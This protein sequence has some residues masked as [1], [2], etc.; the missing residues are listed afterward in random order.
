MNSADAAEQNIS[1]GQMVRIFGENGEIRIK[2]SLTEDI[3][4]GVASLDAGRWPE[5]DGGIEVA[6]SANIVTSTEPTRPSGGS[7][8]HSTFVDIKPT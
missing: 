1:D 3:M 7:R 6:G 5:F 4:S 8:T 2:V